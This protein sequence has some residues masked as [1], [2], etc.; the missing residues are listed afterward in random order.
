MP[1]NS[2]GTHWVLDAAVHWLNKWVVTGTPPPRAPLLATTQAS[3]VVFKRDAN[4]NVMGGARS[5]QVDAP[6]AALTGQTG[7]GPGFCFLF[8]T[9]VPFSAAQ[10]HTLYKNHGRFV[11]AWAREIHAEMARAFCFRPTV[12][13]CCTLRLSQIGRNSG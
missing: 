10:L 7:G 8:G 2:G 3:P 13:N 9:T 4:G 11:S 12:A 5:P 6:I 1:V